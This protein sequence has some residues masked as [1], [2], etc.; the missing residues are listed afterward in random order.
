MGVKFRRNTFYLQLLRILLEHAQVS[1]MLSATT[2][3]GMNALHLAAITG[4][5]EVCTELVEHG[6]RAAH[7]R[8]THSPLNPSLAPHH[9][10]HPAYATHVHGVNAVALAPPGGEDRTALDFALRSNMRIARLLQEHGGTTNTL[11]PK[12]G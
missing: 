4:N 6:A 12:G 3:K 5:L 7:P 1:E 2:P 8:S 11:P 10:F 9:Y